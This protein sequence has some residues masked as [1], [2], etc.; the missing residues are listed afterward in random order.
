MK[1]SELSLEN[2]RLPDGEMKI[3]LL[4]AI[5]LS[6]SV[7]PLRVALRLLR[8]SSSRYHSWKNETECGLD[9]ISSCPRTSPQQITRTEVK[10]IQDMVTSEYYRHVPT[11]RLAI[12]AQR[13][14]KVFASPTTWSRP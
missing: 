6:L 9:D 2:S 3:K 5:K 13:L 14:G 8:L 1:V 4:R 10:T 12:L 11:N 7:L